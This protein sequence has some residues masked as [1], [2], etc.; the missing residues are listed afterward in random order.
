MLKTYVTVL[1]GTTRDWDG[2]LPLIPVGYTF[3]RRGV[4]LVVTASHITL[5]DDPDADEGGTAAQFV[6]VEPIG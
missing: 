4:K 1:S 5:E 2:M 3:H 6:S